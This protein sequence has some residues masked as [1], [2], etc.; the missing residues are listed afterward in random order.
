MVRAD[1]ERKFMAVFDF[2]DW[3]HDLNA[4]EPNAEC[5]VA[6]FATISFPLSNALF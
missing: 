5:F 2:A 6:V 3:L 1:H 4:L